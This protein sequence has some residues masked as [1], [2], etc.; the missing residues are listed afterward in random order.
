[1][2]PVLSRHKPVTVSHNYFLLEKH[3]GSCR[4]DRFAVRVEFGWSHDCRL[5]AGIVVVLFVV[6]VS[7]RLA[8]KIKVLDSFP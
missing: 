3:T 2:L 6:T 4:S 5:E 7:S 8:R 1:M